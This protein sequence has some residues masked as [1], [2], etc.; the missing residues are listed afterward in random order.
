MHVP[1]A[2]KATLN[3]KKITHYLLRPDHPEGGPK[4]RFFM[5]CGFSHDNVP[6]FEAALLAHPVR[7][8]I[9]KTTKSPLGVKYSV[10]CTL[11]TPDGRNP[12]IRTIWI[13]DADGTPPRFVTAY[14][15]L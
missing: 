5:A 9:A 8:V 1:D 4:A 10:E 2:D 14:P 3:L 15:F 6:A 11:T 12:C 13:D 7:N